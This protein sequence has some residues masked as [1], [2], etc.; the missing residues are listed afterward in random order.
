MQKKK[1]KWPWVLLAVVLV[2]LLAG[3]WL[4]RRA[5]LAAEAITYESYTVVKG[6]ITSTITG[7][8]RLQSADT[9]NVT[10]PDGIEV[11]EVPVAAGDGVKAGDVLAVFDVDS[12]DERAAT[13]LSQLS[14]LDAELA[15]M[16]NSKT[17]EAVYAPLAG[18]LKYLAVAEGDDILTAIAEK[19]ALAL[20]ST[21]GLMQLEIA[22]EALAPG[23]EVSVRWEGG[24]ETGTVAARTANGCL[25]TLDDAKAP[26]GETAE[27]YDGETLVGSG[28]LGIHAPA[29][30]LATGGTIGEINYEIDDKL[31]VTSKLFTVENG[32]FTSAYQLKYAQ[33]E[34]AAKQLE[35]VLLYIADPR[36]LA[37]EDGIVGAVNVTEGAKTG[38]SSAM[39]GGSTSSG[40]DS[41]AFVLLTG[42]AVRMTVSVD[43]LDIHSIVLGQSATVA[44]DAF[45]AEK[46]PGTVTHISN[47]GET[48]KSVASFAVELTLEPDERLMQGMNGSATI[49]VEQLNDVLLIPVAAINE[50]ASGMFVYVGDELAKTYI[51]T[52]LSDGENAQITSGLSEG[53]V[54][55]YADGETMY[56]ALLNFRNQ[57]RGGT[58]N[59]G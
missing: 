25:V 24:S 41:A 31:S 7:S 59:R 42:G 22:S 54:V 5:R 1:R 50:D 45:P 10:V 49:L 23:D 38:A 20:I 13:L 28:T 57:M 53:D 3:T 37:P 46:F 12:L 56:Q 55:K 2:L 14:A 44:L 34:D 27:V 43:E 11:T 19:G 36:V 21:D 15:R 58:S 29:S 26:Y 16:G 39:A 35:K 52:G 48:A 30:V 4:V 32:P 8:G 47:L 51:T 18:R 40:G 9:L 17:V 6:S 33:R